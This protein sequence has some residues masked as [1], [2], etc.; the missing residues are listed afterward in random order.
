[1]KKMKDSR[2]A[3]LRLDVQTVR[4]LQFGALANVVGGA[5]SAS[6]CGQGEPY[7]PPV[8]QHGIE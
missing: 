2:K 1:M 4:S 6:Q 8:S 5:A 7:C 3:S